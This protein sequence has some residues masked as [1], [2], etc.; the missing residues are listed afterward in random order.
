M[1]IAIDARGMKCPWPAVRL[2]KALRE[3][4]GET[5]EI[6][7]DDPAAERELTQLAVAA[8]ANIR[9]IEDTEL[10]GFRVIPERRINS[11]F[12]YGD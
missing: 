2:A 12:T 10:R 1:A 5:I 9:A 3:H 6:L 4:P 7:A 8:G 11:V